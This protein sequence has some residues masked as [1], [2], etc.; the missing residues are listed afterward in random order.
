MPSP[1]RA[2]SSASGWPSSLLYIFVLCLLTAP[3]IAAVPND[4]PLCRPVPG[5]AGWPSVAIWN[6]FNESLGG[7]LLQPAPPGAVCHQGQPGYDASRCPDLQARW[8]SSE[9]HQSDPVSSMWSN[10]NNDSC[11]PDPSYP[12]SGQGYPIF[13]VNASTALHV[14]AGIDFARKHGIRLIVKSTGHDYLGRSSAPN[15]LSIWTR[16]LKGFVVAD[17]FQPKGCGVTIEGGVVTAGAGSQMRETYEFLGT[18]NRTAVGGN[19]PTVSLGGYITGGGHSILGPRHGMAVDQ[20]LE[21]EVVTPS[22]EIVTANE[23]TNTD[24]FWALRGGGGSTFGILTSV[25]MKTFPSPKMLHLQLTIFAATSPAA[26]NMPAVAAY[27]LTHFPALGDQGLSGWFFAVQNWTAAALTGVFGVMALQDTDDPADMRRLWDPILAHVN[28]TWPGLIIDPRVTPYPNFAQW[29]ANH[30]DKST[31]G[32]DQYVAGR[33]LDDAALT[34]NTAAMRDIVAQ[35][36]NNDN[37]GAFIVSGKGVWNAK[38]RGGST[39]VLPAWKNVHVHAPITIVFP[40]LNETAKAEAY[41]KAISYT[42]PYKT[43][44]PNTGAY[45][46]EAFVHEPDWQTQFWGTNYPRLLA[47]KRAVDPDDV[48]WCQPCVG[49]ER[50]REEGDRLCRVKACS[51]KH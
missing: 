27:I 33:L 28:A 32:A 22:G 5:T 18:I 26:A 38:P 21:M 24:L 6:S 19:G 44:S 17:S 8:P 42:E 2:L 10:F 48:L 29:Y 45:V 47:I 1:M 41:Q 20:V 31:V 39:A 12:C 11:L 34:N 40:P 13:V 25:T 50:W 15:A 37:F 43:L 49:N 23:C 4:S 16:N 3:I 46:N 30:Y 35:I 14:K 7:R 51:K 36:K 9:F